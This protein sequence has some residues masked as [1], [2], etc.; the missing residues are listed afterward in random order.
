MV[1]MHNS[2]NLRMLRQLGHLAAAAH[3]H[4]VTAQ[5]ARHALR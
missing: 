2:M 3:D 5:S 1:L 4:H